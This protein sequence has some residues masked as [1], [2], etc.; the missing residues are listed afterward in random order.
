M[1]LWRWNPALPTPWCPCPT[2]HNWSNRGFYLGVITCHSGIRRDKS[3]GRSPG[4]IYLWECNQSVAFGMEIVCD[5]KTVAQSG[6]KVLRVFGLPP[7]H[8]STWVFLAGVV[9]RLNADHSMD[10]R[11]E[12]EIQDLVLNFWRKSRSHDGSAKGAKRSF[13]MGDHFHLSPAMA[14]YSKT[15]Y[16]AHWNA[17]SWVNLFL[18]EVSSL[19]SWGFETKIPCWT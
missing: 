18:V 4:Q 11:V 6:R 10:V 7:D 15:L 9:E 17:R 19:S 3:T 1:Q 5:P 8:V 14:I 12:Q 2:W 16:S 13:V